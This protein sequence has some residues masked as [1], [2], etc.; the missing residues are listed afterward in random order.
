MLAVGS[1]LLLLLL[2]M[3][4]EEEEEEV[5][6]VVAENRKILRCLC[7]SAVGTRLKPCWRTSAR[8]PL[9]PPPRRLPLRSQAVS[10]GTLGSFCSSPC[11]P[12]SLPAP[13]APCLPRRG[14]EASPK[15][16]SR[17]TSQKRPLPS[18]TSSMSWTAGWPRKRR[19]TPSTISS[20]CSL[21]A[22]PRPR[23]G[24]AGA[25]R[26]EPARECASASTR[27][28]GTAELLGTSQQA[29]AATTKG[30][31]KGVVNNNTSN[32]TAAWFPPRRK[33][34]HS[35]LLA[36]QQQQRCWRQIKNRILL[37]HT[38]RPLVVWEQVNSS[39]RKKKK[40][41]KTVALLV[42]GEKTSKLQTP[43]NVV[44]RQVVFRDKTRRP[45]EVGVVSTR[46][47]ATSKRL[48]CCALL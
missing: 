27:A 30:T 26:G 12:S 48:N 15:S 23:L 17:P 5:P 29:A 38:R 34:C 41:K 39:K 11:T 44:V 22:S 42:A 8:R 20:A 16:C 18:P 32:K 10:L 47:C 13:S 4:K 1:L 31:T 3:R 33:D 35:F 36:W 28:G 40:K 19:T 14:T 45:P 46:E 7:F 24:S 25:G 43:K 9:R 37:E 6:V 2:E 21:A